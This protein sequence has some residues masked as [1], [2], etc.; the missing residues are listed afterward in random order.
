M[1]IADQATRHVLGEQRHLRELDKSL[2]D[3]PGGGV[4]RRSASDDEGSLRLMEQFDGLL[5]E[6]GDLPKR[7][8]R[9][10]TR[11]AGRTS[12]RLR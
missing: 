11:S 3:R 4:A 8:L 5:D 12:P 2:Q 6:L 7:V 10:D 1:V 9:H